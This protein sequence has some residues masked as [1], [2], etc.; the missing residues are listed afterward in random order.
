MLCADLSKCTDT[1]KEYQSLPLQETKPIVTAAEKSGE[2]K[3]E[4]S[5]SDLFKLKEVES[6]DDLVSVELRESVPTSNTRELPEML[7]V[8]KTKSSTMAFIES[9]F[10]GS[11]AKVRDR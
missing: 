8:P 7:T 1:D 6:E 2:L 3:R 5:Q 9:I 4:L 10:K 11:S